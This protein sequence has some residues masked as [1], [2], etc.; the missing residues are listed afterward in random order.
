LGAAL[1]PE[2]ARWVGSWADGLITVAGR[3]D[4]MR[5]VVD[6]FRESAG[7]NKPMFLQ[8]A[9][10]FAPTDEEAACAAHD[11]WRHCLLTATQLAD[12]PSPSAIDEATADVAACGVMSKVRVSSNVHRHLEWFHQDRDMGFERIYM[13]NVARDYQEHFIEACANHLIPSFNRASGYQGS[14]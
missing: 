5:A 1:S 3:R 10:W 12:L 13:H 14:R 9:V 11:Q 7:H 2:T 6:A 8:A 4:D